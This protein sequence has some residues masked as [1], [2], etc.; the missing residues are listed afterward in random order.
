MRT[1]VVVHRRRGTAPEAGVD[2]VRVVVLKL[3][4]ETTWSSRVCVAVIE[5][6][7]VGERRG[8]VGCDV[9]E[10]AEVGTVAWPIGVVPMYR[11]TVSFGDDAVDLELE[12]LAGRRIVQVGHACWRPGGGQNVIALGAR[13]KCRP[14]PACESAE[15]TS[16]ESDWPGCDGHVDREDAGGPS[17]KASRSPVRS[18]L[19]TRKSSNWRLAGDTLAEYVDRRRRW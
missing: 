9:T 7:S 8:A 12:C 13:E 4:T 10:V 14:G 19:L 18:E 1:G 17:S 5:F 2:Q 11:W 6:G 15:E 16:V 3:P